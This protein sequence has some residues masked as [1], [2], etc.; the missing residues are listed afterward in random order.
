MAHP[1]SSKENS[2][3][4]FSQAVLAKVRSIIDCF[5]YFTETPSG[6]DIAATMWSEYKHYAIKVLVAITPTGGIAGVSPAYLLLRI[7]GLWI[8]CKKNIKHCKCQD[9]C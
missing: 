5:E 3:K 2:S 1:W 8:I 7:V 6:L 4:L 9:L